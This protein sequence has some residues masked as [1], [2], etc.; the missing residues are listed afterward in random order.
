V[1]L[2]VLSD[3]YTAADR[4]QVTLL[5]LLDQ[6]SA[7][8][9]VDHAILF[10]RLQFQYGIR[11]RALDWTISYLTGRTQYV[12]YNGESSGISPV[13][14]GVPQGSVLGPQYFVLYSAEIISLVEDLGFQVHG[15]ADDLQ[16]YKH[17]DPSSAALLIP[18][19]S[20]CID[21][22][23][24]WMA[25]NRL[26]LN[27]NKTEIIWL[28]TKRRLKNCSTEPQFISGAW[29]TPSTQVRDL[30]VTIDSELSMIPHVNKVVSICYFH[31][32]QLRLLRRS[33][34]VSSIHALVRSLIH[35]RLDYCN[36]LLAGSPD[37]LIKKLQSVLRSS[38]RLILKIP[39]HS[40]VT[41]L[42]ANNLH[43]LNFPQRITYKLAV[44]CFRC[45]QA[46]APA[47]LKR[48]F[49]SV[50]AVQGR[51]QLRSATSGQLVVPYTHTKTVGIRGF[52]F[53]GPVTWNSLPTHIRVNAMSTSFGTFKKSLKTILFVDQMQT[54]TATQQ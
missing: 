2:D 21:K 49:N 15:Y 29:I 53:S 30:G 18:M 39:S 6:S 7:F 25:S 38:A 10:N 9:M 47:Y 13:L 5:G 43:W 11:D 40:S 44:L 41:D 12:H 14:Y 35:S 17:S 19:M 22:I 50:S 37:Y 8:D 52:Y 16:I 46:D 45:Q 36:S 54:R 20:D 42:M 27:P 51:S 24:N 26:R 34:D 4:G 32:R 28:G 31:I 33:L 23:K 48:R 1:L 3:A